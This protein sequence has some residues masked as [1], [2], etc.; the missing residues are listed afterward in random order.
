MRSNNNVVA[1]QQSFDIKE[2]L[3]SCKARWKWFVIAFVLFTL[4]GVWKFLSNVPTYDVNANI[5]IY[6]ETTEGGTIS[7][8]RQFSLG[9]V[10]GGS[11]D[12]NNELH[13]LQSHTVM[14]NTAKQL[15]L[16]I[17]Y[18]V[19]RGFKR[20]ACYP[21]TT[22]LELVCNP[23]IADTI[24]VGLKFEVKCSANGMADI[25]V[26]T[27]KGTIANVKK[28]Q[29]PA[30]VETKYGDFT[31]RQTPVY[32]QGESVK[33]TITFG[34]YD[35]AAERYLEKVMISI[36]DRKS[37]LISLSINI[38]DPKFGQQI[39]DAIIANYNE[40]GIQ[41]KQE[42]DRKTAAFIDQRLLSLTD[43]LSLSEE[44]IEN[45]QKDKNLIDLSAEAQ[46]ILTKLTN[47]EANLESAQ[48]ELSLLEQ[49]RDFLSKPG[50]KYSLLPMG[51][52]A[53]AAQGLA[54]GYNELILRR[55]Q[56]TSGAKSD[57]AVLR[58]LDEQIDATRDNI[59]L[60][61]NKTIETQKF[62]YDELKSLN[63]EYEGKLQAFPAEQRLFRAIER[64]QSVKEQ[65][66][67]FLLQQREETAISIA[68]AQPRAIIVDEAYTLIDAHKVSLKLLL[69]AIIFFT[70]AIPMAIIFV[71]DKL[72]TKVESRKEIERLCKLP[73]LGEVSEAKNAP[74]VIQNG[75]LSSIAE[76]FRLIR[77]NIQF[78]LA[79]KKEKVIIVTSTN[80]G[81]G[82][83]FVA[84]NIAAAMSIPNSKVLLIGADIRRPK[85]YRYLNVHSQF[86]LTEYLSSDELT[87]DDIINRNPVEGTQMD[88]ITAGPVPPN[89]S[90]LLMSEKF[91]KLIE[92]LRQRYDY[93]V[94]DSAPMGLV[95]DTLNISRVADATVFVCRVDTTR[96]E[97]F[98]LINE[99]AD[100]VRL[101][102]MALLINGVTG[103]D[104]TYTYQIEEDK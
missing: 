3:Q 41:E 2:F 44:D 58:T 39:L 56:L 78:I 21:G 7:L 90:E 93:I 75:T 63:A 91:D 65:L 36:P 33:E 19:K 50:N 1:D 10:L 9:S 81:E 31:I 69:I 5:M 47:L 24:R 49:T 61:V 25:K 102:K 34:S 97:D 40:K 14:A 11:G 46:I 16:N 4:F 64:Q 48:T 87:V 6:S 29:L 60:T 38:A 26:K 53:A 45:F 17:G 20:I 92:A 79:S 82:K 83:T 59:L 70:L 85:L 84:I 28:A 80:S 42:R 43:E 101:K 71:R 15:L 104:H 103:K 89:P 27:V 99:L 73:I 12:V 13:V 57:N 95:S 62:K 67:L 98:K 8:A 86:G 23:S 32:P 52:T 37:D 18:E 22:P 35:G 54:T 51:Q 100:D 74:L 76:Q 77:A 72:R 66:Y 55:M 88:V 30:V 68:N 96:I 94:I